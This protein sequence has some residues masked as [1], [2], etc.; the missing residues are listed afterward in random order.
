MRISYTK[1]YEIHNESDDNTTIDDIKCSESKPQ[2]SDGVD[3]D[4]PED[5]LVDTFDPGCHV[6]DTITGAYDPND[7]TEKN[8]RKPIF[9]EF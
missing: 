9:I 5:T 6:G 7:D 3:N 4:D 8:K 1:K 2:C